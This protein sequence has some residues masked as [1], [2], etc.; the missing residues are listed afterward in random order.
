MQNL[1]PSD[2][3]ATNAK[4]AIDGAM[5]DAKAQRVAAAPVERPTTTPTE[6]GTP[7]AARPPSDQS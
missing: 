3:M 6:P 4:R 1:K 7:A 2:H 5:A